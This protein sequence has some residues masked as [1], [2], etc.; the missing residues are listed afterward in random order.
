MAV[1]VDA[2]GTESTNFP[3]SST[4]LNYTGLTV[5]SGLTNSALLAIIVTGNQNTFPPGLAATWNGT[6]LTLI[7]NTNISVSSGG[8]H[9][10]LFGLASPVAGNQTLAV[11]WTGGSTYS[12]S[13]AALSFQ[14][15]D[16]TTPFRN[17]A[18]ATATSNTAAVTVTSATGN[19]VVGVYA[20][21]VSYGGAPSGTQIFSDTGASYPVAAASRNAG[22]TPTLSDGFSS[23]TLWI[24]S[25]CDVKA[26]VAGGI[27]NK[28]YQTNYTIKRASYY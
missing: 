8:F 26:A 3:G 10:A 27:P 21:P 23:S 15:V 17:G 22:A 16:Q 5:G 24:A 19:I 4:G 6:S 7:S 14:G 1:T 11:S 13:I 18:T 9:I 28:I 25:G 12:Y 20:G 2:T